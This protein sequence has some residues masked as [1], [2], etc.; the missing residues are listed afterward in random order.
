MDRHRRHTLERRPNETAAKGL[1]RNGSRRNADYSPQRHREHRE[2]SSKTLSDLRASVVNS[3]YRV[4]G[5]PEDRSRRKRRLPLARLDK[6]YPR[7]QLLT[8]EDLLAGKT[9]D[10]PPNLQTY[11]QAGKVSSESKDQGMLGFGE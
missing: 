11:K 3:S 9:V 8:V 1:V 10:L 2:D 6:D 4:I 5:Q 7:L